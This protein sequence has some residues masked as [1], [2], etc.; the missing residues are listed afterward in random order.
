MDKGLIT[1]DG[2]FVL[3]TVAISRHILDVSYLYQE[4]YYQG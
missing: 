3:G 4:R 1:Y 2:K